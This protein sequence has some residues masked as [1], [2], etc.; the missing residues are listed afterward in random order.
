MLQ[1]LPVT[2]TGVDEP[3]VARL[4]TSAQP[5][6]SLA[7]FTRSFGGGM[8]EPWCILFR[9]QMTVEPCGSKTLDSVAD[10]RQPN[11]MT[12]EWGGR[13]TATARFADFGIFFL[14]PRIDRCDRSLQALIE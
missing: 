7:A 1:G 8:A 6:L 5:T 4:N 11:R 3:Q 14:R 9:S 13:E 2:V 10:R 12:N